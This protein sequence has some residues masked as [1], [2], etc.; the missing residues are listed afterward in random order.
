MVVNRGR[1]RRIGGGGAAGQERSLAGAVFKLL[2]KRG[3][4]TSCPRTR[5]SL[6]LL[7]LDGTT[8]PPA[9]FHSLQSRSCLSACI[10]PGELRARG[11]LLLTMAAELSLQPHLSPRGAI[12]I[13]HDQRESPSC[14][15]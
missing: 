13:Q 6:F 12:A 10:L 2:N 8:L 15:R 11:S 9:C 5:V 14:C 1:F 7:V 4:F 3:A